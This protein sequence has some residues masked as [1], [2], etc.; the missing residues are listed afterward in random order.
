MDRFNS[1]EEIQFNKTGLSEGRL[2]RLDGKPLSSNPY[3]LDTWLFKSF[4]AG[5]CDMDMDENAPKEELY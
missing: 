1:S 2:A 4:V 3:P 5:W